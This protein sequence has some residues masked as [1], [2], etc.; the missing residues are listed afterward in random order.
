VSWKSCMGVEAGGS[1]FVV[2]YGDAGE[3][4]MAD[5]GVDAGAFVV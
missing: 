3:V 5:E 1:G 4:W 2:Y